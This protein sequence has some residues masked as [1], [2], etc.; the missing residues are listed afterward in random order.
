MRGE[1][2]MQGRIWR[3]V[4][5]LFAA[6]ICALPGCS[7]RQDLAEQRDPVTAPAT[8]AEAM[9]MI[10]AEEAKLA[11]QGPQ[12]SSSSLPET[13]AGDE[14]W[15]AGPPGTFQLAGSQLQLASQSASLADARYLSFGI[16]R[17]PGN[18]GLSPQHFF[19]DMQS[20]PTA[21]YTVYVV[22]YF[23]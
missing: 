23:P 7:G 6:L 11:K 10:K 16:F 18:T 3:P 12:H 5:A 2:K 9:S 22:R 20:D 17:F 15:V 1:M 19:L 4:F 8:L 13:Q 14:V 21:E